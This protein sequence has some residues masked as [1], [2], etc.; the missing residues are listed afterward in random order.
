MDRSALLRKIF[1]CVLIA[2]VLFLIV[3]ATRELFRGNLL[4]AMSTCPLLLVVY[5]F[6]LADK[7]RNR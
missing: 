5:L 1:A 7:R 3:F 4:A 6:V 2:V